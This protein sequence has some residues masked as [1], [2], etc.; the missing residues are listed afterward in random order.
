MSTQAHPPTVGG[1]DRLVAGISLACLPAAVAIVA[2]GAINN[3]EGVLLALAGIALVIAGGW[4]AVS[5]RGGARTAGI[6]AALAGLSVLVA[7][8]VIADLSWWR[9]LSAVVLG[10]V[11]TGTAR[12][13][14]ERADAPDPASL[15]S[16]V[17]AAAHATLI[18][19]PVSGGGKATRFH[20][21]DECAR[22]GIEAIVL[23]KGDDLVQLAEDAVARGTDVIGMAGG[24]GSQA[25]V[26]DVARRHGIPLV[27]I[28]A[29]TRNHFALDL[30]LDRD[31]VVGR[32]PGCKAAH[33]RGHAPRHPGPRRR[34][35]RPAL[36]G[37]R[38]RGA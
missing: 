5:R 13:A 19:N 24:D 28:P 6:V 33:R 34:A 20:V 12:S 15:G 16:P 30:G 25:L 36:P 27:V 2:V 32:V 22:R 10:V 17:P 14:L 7:A 18:M 38:R 21:A 4:Y 29:G 1:G 23:N 26:A 3:V 31:D 9:I 8:L 11:A 37:C 35:V